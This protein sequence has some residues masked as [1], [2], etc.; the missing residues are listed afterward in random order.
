MKPEDDNPTEEE[1]REAAALAAAL[2]GDAARPDAGEGAAPADALETAALLR[3]ARA[4]LAVPPAHEPIAA[5][6]AAPVLDA[7][8]AGGRRRS[9]RWIGASLIVPM[10]A[11]AW[12]M[13][14]AVR[15]TSEMALAPPERPP[16]PT[17]DLLAAQAEAIRGGSNA[18]AALAALDSK[19]RAYRRQY[20]EDLR[21]RGGGEP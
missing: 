4:P 8:R 1:L 5:A 6:R 13:Y 2:E 3:H 15:S 7:R 12:L 17:A 11:A 18:G 21:R 20:H 16:A 19:M 10:A 9:R 14:A